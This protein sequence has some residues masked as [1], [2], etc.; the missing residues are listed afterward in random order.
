LAAAPSHSG[1]RRHVHGFGLDR[2]TSAELLA[3]FVGAGT[4]EQGLDRERPPVGGV[5]RLD[6]LLRQD[7]CRIV[8]HELQGLRAPRSGHAGRQQQ[9][10]R[11]PAGARSAKVGHRHRSV[12]PFEDR[13]PSNNRRAYSTVSRSIVNAAPKETGFSASVSGRLTPARNITEYPSIQP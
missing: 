3:L 4:V 5:R 2:N 13:P 11:L 12:T 7:L 6:R 1:K 8:F 9:Y 10:K